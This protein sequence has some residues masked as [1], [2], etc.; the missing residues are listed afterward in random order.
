MDGQ[1]YYPYDIEIS[2]KKYLSEYYDV[3]EVVV[4]SVQND[5]QQDEL[6]VI[7]EVSLWLQTEVNLYENIKKMI[8][9]VLANSFEITAHHILLAAKNK[10]PRT[11]SGKLQ[12]VLCKKEFRK[13]A[14]ADLGMMPLYSKNELVCEC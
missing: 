8:L 14:C 12:R 11:S 9:R 7:I 6:I 1:N 2:I 10:I 5:I 13:N 4:F 3:G